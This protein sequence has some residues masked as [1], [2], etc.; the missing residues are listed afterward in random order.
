MPGTC[1]GA[2]K[3]LHDVRSELEA[4]EPAPLGVRERSRAPCSCGATA[5]ASPRSCAARMH[6]AMYC[7]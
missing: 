6:A 7:R 2:G 5:R 1:G 3:E 4:S